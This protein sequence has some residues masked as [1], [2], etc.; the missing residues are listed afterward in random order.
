MRVPEMF[1]AKDTT[2]DTVDANGV[3]RRQNYPYYRVPRGIVSQ[4]FC[5]WM[6]QGRRCLVAGEPHAALTA[7]LH[8]SEVLPGN[9]EARISVCEARV[10]CGELQSAVDE[11]EPLL[12]EVEHADPWIIAALAADAAGALDDLSGF[13]RT[14]CEHLEKGLSCELRQETLSILV[15]L[16]NLY[17]GGTAIEPGPAGLLPSIALRRPIPGELEPRPAWA[18]RVGRCVKNLALKGR[19]DWIEP[20]LE[21]RADA[22]IPGAHRAARD[23][24]SELGIDV[25]DDGEVSLTFVHASTQA[26]QEFTASLFRAHTDLDVHLTR[27]DEVP[28]ILEDVERSRAGA[29]RQIWV[30]GFD[31]PLQLL[32]AYPKARYLELGRGEPK[33]IHFESNR[34]VCYV[35]YAELLKSPVEALAQ[36]LAFIGERSHE[37][38]LRKL[39]ESYPGRETTAEVM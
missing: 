8:A 6:N 7:F 10:E 17:V 35:G 12:T 19:L 30:T 29:A 16:Y 36:I 28:R 13:L 38:P 33:P 20:F 4:E 27:A 25:V 1:L 34:R 21:P 32:S 23:G 24:L 14:A 9:V 15:G 11:I 5:E 22:L 3:E 2:T 39:I 31:V 26:D 37:G 18:P